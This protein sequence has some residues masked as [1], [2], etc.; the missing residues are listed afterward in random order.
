MVHLSDSVTCRKRYYKESGGL[1]SQLW[2]TVRRRNFFM[3]SLL[4]DFVVCCMNFFISGVVGS[5]SKV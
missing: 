3:L 5:V 1:I 4:S 2:S